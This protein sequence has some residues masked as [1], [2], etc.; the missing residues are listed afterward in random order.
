[1]STKKLITLFVAAAGLLVPAAASAQIRSEPVNPP[2]TELPPPQDD[3]D[4]TP[5]AAR[6]A[7]PQA[8]ITKQAG[9]GGTQAYGRAGVLE[10][11]GSLGFTAAEDFAQFNA[12]PSIGWFFADNIQLSALLGIT[13]SS[14]TTTVNTGAGTEDI[15]SS[16]T[17]LSFVIEPSYHL[18]FSDTVFGFLGVGAGFGMVS[19]SVGEAD[20]DDTGFLISPRLGM[21]FMVG[22]SGVLSPYLHVDYTTGEILQVP[23]GNA[24]AVNVA[25][26][27]NIGYTVMW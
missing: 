26:G 5:P 15:E 7:G 3:N 18:P 14:M 4:P 23:G 27:G 8:G 12:T 11:G 10:L 19:N 24:V 17:L 22:R 21:N 1:M 2:P 25:Y 9:V 6:P 20:S 16:S 13:Y